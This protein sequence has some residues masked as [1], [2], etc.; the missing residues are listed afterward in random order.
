MTINYTKQEQIV[1]INCL[2]GTYIN[3]NLQ[4]KPLP[5]HTNIKHTH[6]Y[7]RTHAI[8][9]IVSIPSAFDKE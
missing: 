3:Y 9:T 8:T 6:I 2:L 4:G 7:A 5:I 1:R